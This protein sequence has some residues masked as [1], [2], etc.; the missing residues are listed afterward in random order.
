MFRKSRV[1]PSV[2]QDLLNKD[3]DLLGKLACKIKGTV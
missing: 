1:P 2:A 3:V